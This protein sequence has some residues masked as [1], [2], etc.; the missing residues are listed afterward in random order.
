MKLEIGESLML[1]Y[2]K[3]IKKCVFYQTNWKISSNWETFNDE[4]VQSLY[5]KIR[6]DL[7][8]DVFKKSTLSQSLKQAEVDAIGMDS[9]NTIYAVDIAF[10]EAG[11][12]YG[13]KDETK[14]RVIKKLLR[15]YLALL[16]YFPDKNYE[17]IFVSPKVHNATEEVIRIYFKEL[18]KTF[19]NEKVKFRYISNDAFRDEIVIPTIKNTNNDS[20]TNELFLRVAKMLNIFGLYSVPIS[21]IETT[22]DKIDDVN[23]IDEIRLINSSANFTIEFVPNN[24]DIFKQ[25]LLQVKKA[26][27]TWYYSDGR[28][29]KDTWDAYKF[30]PESNLRGN[31]LSN[32]KVRKRDESGLFKL[33]IEIIE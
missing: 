19:S 31:I 22:I 8:F 33:K 1:S 24:E 15:S 27:R 20:D 2:L 17:L 7:V 11:L 3:H 14:D 28:V 16:S 25:K 26:D 13:S 32:N 21:K 6:S 18:E 23:E 9:G 29:V 30:T 4:K 10:H 5:D 12:N